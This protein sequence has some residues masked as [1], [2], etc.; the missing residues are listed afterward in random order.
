MHS[1]PN[2]EPT[3]RAAADTP[4]AWFASDEEGALVRRWAIS[5]GIAT[6]LV[7]WF[8]EG[9][10][11][12]LGVILLYQLFLSTRSYAITG[13]RVFL[14]FT[15][16]PLVLVSVTW[17]SSPHVMVA[18]AV[19]ATLLWPLVGL[20]AVATLVAPGRL[21]RRGWII[22]GAAATLG[23]GAYA[24]SVTRFTARFAPV[25]S[26][27]ELAG[28]YRVFP[29][30]SFPLMVRPLPAVIVLDTTRWSRA[31]TALISRSASYVA[32]S[33]RLTPSLAGA[34][35][36][37]RDP[38]YGLVLID[39]TYRGLGGTRGYFRRDGEDLVGRLVQYQDAV[40]LAPMPVQSVRFKRTPCTTAGAAAARARVPG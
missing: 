37:W 21:Q 35:G 26:P 23:V 24:D 17:I 32:G 10:F 33:R 16:I 18:M 3:T 22:W 13:R 9:A 27:A 11:L 31:D 30:L 39:W 36:R 7:W 34:A 12:L 14:L 29:G 15:A 8:R 19:F 5:S 2:A 1:A 20:S 25:P 6:F 28:C 38:E 40:R 4:M